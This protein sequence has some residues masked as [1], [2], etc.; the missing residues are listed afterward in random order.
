M[1][2]MN[3]TTK[4]QPLDQVQPEQYPMSSMND[5]QHV[6]EGHPEEDDIMMAYATQLHAPGNLDAD[7]ASEDDSS[8]RD[9]LGNLDDA[10]NL[11]NLMNE[12]EV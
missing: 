5:D 4:F 6:E 7:Q 1:S 11:F 3:E 12:C 9:A 10:D 2:S 8:N